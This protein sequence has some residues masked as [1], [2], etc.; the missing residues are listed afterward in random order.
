MTL[1]AG[2]KATEA[3]AM[4]RRINPPARI[5]TT[6]SRD[7]GRLR[8]LTREFLRARELPPSRVYRWLTEASVEVVL[9]LMARMERPELRKPIGDFFSRTR[10]VRPV[11]RG[12]ELRAL[13][14]RPG[15]IYR[16]I[17]NSLLYAR[18]DGHVQN[19]DD[20]LRF[21]RRRIARAFSTGAPEPGS[22]SV[23]RRTA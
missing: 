11:L 16:D 1:L 4:L 12:D 17:L 19:R 23:A 2:Q 7:L 14:I 13:G 6:I 22:P 5:A 10:R 21:V 18:L 15:P 8:A 3:R 9:A 20:E